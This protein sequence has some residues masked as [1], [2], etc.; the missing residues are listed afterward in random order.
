MDV[1]AG[2]IAASDSAPAIA[3]VF[4]PAARGVSDIH[5]WARNSMQV[6]VRNQTHV[7]RWT[8]QA[9]GKR[10]SAFEALDAFGWRTLSQLAEKRVAAIVEDGCEVAPILRARREAAGLKVEQVAQKVG[11]STADVE[12]AES[13]RKR[14]PIR[15]LT[16]L[17]QALALDA[18][19]I[20]A[21]KNGGG[22]PDLGVRFR[23]LQSGP[24]TTSAAA[25][26]GLA[27]AAWVIAT[28]VRLERWFDPARAG[29]PAALGFRPAH[30]R[31]LHRAAWQDGMD[32]AHQTRELL[33]LR[34]DA[35]IR[36]LK[37]LAEDR[38][39]IPLVQAELPD[40]FAGATI[41]NG[42]AR[43][44]V[45]NVKGIN[46]K[47]WTRRMTVAHELGHLLWDVDEDLNRLRVD[48]Y[49]S[50][51]A[52]WRS[53][54][55]KV[56]MRANAFAAELLA[57]Q[58]AVARLFEAEGGSD[59]AVSEIMRRFGISY[60]AASWQIYNSLNRM[61]DREKLRSLPKTRPS[62][63]WETDEAH[64]ASY[65]TLRETP[66]SRQGRFAELCLRAYD[67]NL[68]SQDTAADYLGTNPG[69][70]V[71]AAPGLRNL[72]SR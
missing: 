70:F 50:L 24:G 69:A 1:N 66:L 38:L 20:G 46:R 29:I 22:D 11:L 12:A 57:P 43:G 32:L 8:P 63:E 61:I 51:A 31:T 19:K 26:L 56:E 45:V 2:G 40:K 62:A 72:L 6:F 36:S 30:V 64:A 60:T 17:A 49:A 18:D 44:I 54:P 28:Q 13:G 10:L 5:A 58:V 42:A 41:A 27:D 37:R 7:A 52:D 55:D 15:I 4:G 9:T 53:L 33:G 71:A 48:D 47:V 67:G 59:H 34:H 21:V 25:V 23:E 68:I 14:T 65:F 3:E 16:R 35:P 39:A